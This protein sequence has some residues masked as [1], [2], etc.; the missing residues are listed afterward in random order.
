MYFKNLNWSI[1][2]IAMAVSIVHILSLTSGG[3]FDFGFNNNVTD[4]QDRFQA[5]SLLF[6]K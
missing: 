6:L 4:E 5:C 1:C 2:T 3:D